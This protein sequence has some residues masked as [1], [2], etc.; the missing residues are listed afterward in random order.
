M[1][2]PQ[3]RPASSIEDDQTSTVDDDERIPPSL[4]AKMPDN[5]DATA[6]AF[7]RS[8]ESLKTGGENFKAWRTRMEQA[9]D[10]S[11]LDPLVKGTAKMP[12]GASKA[13]EQET[14]KH[15]EKRARALLLSKME[16]GE[17]SQVV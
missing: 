13:A 2:Q 5:P 14:W 7:L 6:Y 15:E 17:L 3:A 16:D 4:E 9:L 12:E 10:L 1:A 8:T 11:D